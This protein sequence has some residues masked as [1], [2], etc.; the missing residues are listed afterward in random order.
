MKLIPALVSVATAFNTDVYDSEFY[1]DYIDHYRQDHGRDPHYYEPPH[2]EDSYHNHAD[3]DLHGNVPNGAFERAVDHF[4]MWEE[5]WD[6]EEYEWR[7]RQEA[8]LMVALEALREDLV[9]LD[10]DIDRLEDCISDN[11][12]GIDDNDRGVDKNDHHISENDEEIE[13]QQRR[14]KYL[15]KRCRRCQEALDT[16][17]DFLV[18]YCQQFAFAA[19][20]VGAC[21]DVL[22]CT[23]TRLA[24]RADLFTSQ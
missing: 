9:T 15:A 1:G 3:D 14:A 4:D 21:A 19:D 2:E 8:D 20:L 17:R 23:G 12:D 24:Y 11:D 16:D 5:V 6:Q 18:L 10:R 13:D 7:L 22:T